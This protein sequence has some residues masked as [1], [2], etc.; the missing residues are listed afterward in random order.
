MNCMPW[1]TRGLFWVPGNLGDLVF[2]LYFPCPDTLWRH[3]FCSH[4]KFVLQKNLPDGD[5]DF[6]LLH[7][8][9]S[10]LQGSQH[11]SQR[12]ALERRERKPQRRCNAQR[13]NP[14]AGRLGSEM[15]RA[16]Q[17]CYVDIEN[18]Y[19]IIEW[20]G[21]AGTLKSIQFQTPSVSRDTFH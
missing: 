21:L 4:G 13:C 6:N 8:P 5:R 15:L 2:I 14:P 9:D 20:F 12:Q 3:M 1:T 16:G 10:H 17:V 7:P 11:N 19:R 18:E